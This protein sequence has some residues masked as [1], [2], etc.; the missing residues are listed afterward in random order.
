M[1]R[2]KETY[3][4]YVAIEEYVRRA[5]LERALAMGQLIGD[6]VGYIVRGLRALMA[7]FTRIKGEAPL[8]MPR[9]PATR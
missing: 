7:G 9:T 1:D 4:D 3:P 6:S 2:F 5:R 8:T